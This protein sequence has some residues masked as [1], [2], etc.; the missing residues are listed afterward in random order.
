MVDHQVLNKLKRTQSLRAIT[1]KLRFP[2]VAIFLLLALAHGQQSYG[3]SPG[4]QPAVGAATL[5]PNA[6]LPVGSGTAPV[7][8]APQFEAGGPTWQPAVFAPVRPT[9]YASYADQI[10]GGSAGGCTDLGCTDLS[11]GGQSG[12]ECGA[13]CFADAFAGHFPVYGTW[14][15]IDFMHVWTK[16]RNLPSLVTTSPGATPFATAGVLPAATTLFGGRVGEGR[17]SAGRLDMGF[18]LDECHSNGIG[19]RLF[20]IEGDRSGYHAQSDAAGVPILATPYFDFLT[21]QNAAI[22]A[23]HPTNFAG[24]IGVQTDNDMLS[25][26]MYARFLMIR[27]GLDRIDMIGGYHYAQVSD[28]LVLTSTAEALNGGFGFPVGTVNV[29]TDRFDV[30]NDF[31]GGVVGFTVEFHRGCWTLRT[32]TKVSLGDMRHQVTIDGISVTTIPPPPAGG[33]TATAPGGIFAQKSN[34]GTRT[35]NQFTYIPEVNLTLG[36]KVTPHV[37]LT[38]GYNFLYFPHIALVGDQIDTTVD[39]SQANNGPV[40]VRP[41]LTAIRDTDFWAQGISMGANWTF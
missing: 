17:Q 4:W 15:S 10:G 31:H 22:V 40:G 36:Y 39:L 8:A 7:M 6:A 41:L 32:L 26:E 11:C 29:L 37:E 1:M 20:A 30:R 16:G 12:G 18:W 9:G 23:S 2:F 38:A 24:S 21:N 5:A 3:Q 33:T 34:I 25:A 35:E 14:G 13:S 19:F 27:S 28:G